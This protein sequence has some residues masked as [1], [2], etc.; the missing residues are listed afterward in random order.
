MIKLLTLIALMLLA[1]L[2]LWGVIVNYRLCSL[3]LRKADK[4]KILKQFSVL[5]VITEIEIFGCV[6]IALFYPLPETGFISVPVLRW[7][8]LSISVGSL[9]DNLLIRKIVGMH[10]QPE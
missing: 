1:L 8:I 3:L 6:L 4:D 9:L 2:C 10:F 5:K 7:I